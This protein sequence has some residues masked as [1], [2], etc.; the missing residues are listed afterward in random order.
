MAQQPDDVGVR[1]GQSSISGYPL[2][3]RLCL[4]AGEEQPSR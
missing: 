3:E 1:K 4:G 2:E